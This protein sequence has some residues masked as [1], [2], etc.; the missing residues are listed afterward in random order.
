MSGVGISGRQ[1]RVSVE[2]PTG[3]YTLSVVSLPVWVKSWVHECCGVSRRVDEQV[4]LLLTFHGEVAAT[5]E[6]DGVRVLDDG[7]VRIVG[8]AG[9]RVDHA[10]D[11]TPGTLI[12]SGG[13]QFAIE[14][15][16]PADRVRCTG[17][18]WE[19]RHG[20]PTGLTVG[21]LVDIRW[22]PALLRMVSDVGRSI[23]GYGPGR[24]LQST[25]DWPSSALDPWA[26]E[27]TVWVRDIARG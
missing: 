20:W 12:T 27:L 24:E 7:E 1:P 26:L 25:D 11:A 8:T 16:A 4:E 6:V 15:E 5:D 18:L 22:H 2:L 14:G 10:H 21:R 23:D 9:N 13:V 17:W 3:P 19:D